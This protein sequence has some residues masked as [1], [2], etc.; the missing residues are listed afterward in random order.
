VPDALAYF[1]RG[2]GQREAIV[3]MPTL[4]AAADVAGKLATAGLHGEAT[5]FGR[6]VAR[7]GAQMPDLELVLLDMNI[8]L[9][10]VRQVLF[11]LRATPATARTPVALLAAD[12]RLEAAHRLASEH[13]RVIAV[14][15]PHSAEATAKIA[16]RLLELAER[17]A[18]SA[19]E[20]AQQAVIAIAWTANL[21][22]RGRDYYAVRREGAAIESALYQRATAASAIDALSHFGTADSQRALL[23]F[24]SQ[25]T[26]PIDA[27]RQAASA[28]ET[29]VQAGGLLL[30]SDEILAQYAIYNAS[31]AADSET[32]QVLGALLDVIESRRAKANEAVLNP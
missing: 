30:T 29:S 24:A 4:V 2:A 6:D 12:G 3:A 32:Q 10:G 22:D 8:Q 9:P 17:D 16:M 18:T 11:E 31:A 25:R 20:R 13:E 26:L 27:R 21:L 23:S 28:F 5:Y 14:P 1:A 15:R 19:D 7:M